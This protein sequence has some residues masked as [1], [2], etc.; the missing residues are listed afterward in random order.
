MIVAEAQANPV[1]LAFVRERLAAYG[2]A[3]GVALPESEYVFV[4]AHVCTVTM[5]E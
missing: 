1:E 3:L 2:A 4:T 5:P